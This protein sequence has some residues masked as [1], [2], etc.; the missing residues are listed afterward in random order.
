MNF[1]ERLD[2]ALQ[3]VE[4]TQQLGG[5]PKPWQTLYCQPNKDGSRKKCSNC[6]LWIENSQCVLFKE[7]QR[8]IGD[9]ICGYHVFGTPLSERPEISV[10]QPLD[11]T[12]AGLETIKGGTSCDIC[13][14]FDDGQC[15]GVQGSDGK[16]AMVKP[17]GCCAR[18]VAK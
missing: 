1:N 7:D 11:P 13:E 8:I 4:T 18:W 6:C 15:L 16:P 10:L 14:Y 5:P 9:M 12:L 2:Q 17:K 3:I